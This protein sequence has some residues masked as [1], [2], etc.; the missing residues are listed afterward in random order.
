M[1][2]SREG[3]FDLPSPGR[4]GTGLRSL[5]SQPHHG[6]RTLRPLRPRR[7]FPH[8]RRRHSRKVA[9]LSSNVTLVKGGGGQQ[10]EAY[11]RQPTAEPEAAPR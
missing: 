2:P 9:S 4:R 10:A 1:T 5:S 6:R 11:N 7:R 8:G 3:S